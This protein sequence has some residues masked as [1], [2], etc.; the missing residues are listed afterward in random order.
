MA[1]H[2]VAFTV[3]IQWDEAGGDVTSVKI[4]A[5]DYIDAESY[6]ERKAKALR[7]AAKP[8]MITA[9]ED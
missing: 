7:P 3:F 1:Q 6:G 4:H 2:K 8:F 5:R 9:F